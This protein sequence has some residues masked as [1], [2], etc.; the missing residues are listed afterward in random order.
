[1]LGRIAGSFLF[2]E[3]LRGAR[4]RS[5]QAVANTNAIAKCSAGCSAA[6]VKAGALVWWMQSRS[7]VTSVI[8]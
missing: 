1:M 7:G 5:Y 2:P 6:V 3:T 8:S 4:G